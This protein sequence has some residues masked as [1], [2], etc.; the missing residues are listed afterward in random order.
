MPIVSEESNSLLNIP[1]ANNP[2]QSAMS[3][4][5]VGMSSIDEVQRREG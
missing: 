5:S 2:Y 3:I 4:S 1:I